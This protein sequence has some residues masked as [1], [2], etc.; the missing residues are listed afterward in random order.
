MNAGKIE[1]QLVFKR[2]MK[3]QLIKRMRDVLYCQNKQQEA[4]GMLIRSKKSL[5]FRSMREKEEDKLKHEEKSEEVRLI[6]KTIRFC[7]FVDAGDIFVQE[8]RDKAKKLMK[9]QKTQIKYW[10]KTMKKRVKFSRTA[11]YIK[12]K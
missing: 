11:F 4:I 10:L 9:I 12:T 5:L 8:K 2:I 3:R 1:A 6:I 7:R